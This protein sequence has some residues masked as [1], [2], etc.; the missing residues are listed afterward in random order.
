MIVPMRV[1][2]TTVTPAMIR[3]RMR[4]SLTWSLVN[5]FTYHFKVN[6]SQDEPYLLLEKE[7][8]MI[9]IIGAHRKIRV[10]ILNTHRIFD[11]VLFFFI[12]P[13]PAPLSRPI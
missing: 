7:N 4:A 13:S 3:L 5:S 12:R 11:A 2:I 9:S 6:P 10:R 8:T 1:A